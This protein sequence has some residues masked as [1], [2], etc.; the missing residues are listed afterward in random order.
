[1]KLSFVISTQSTKFK[2]ALFNKN[3]EENI[4]KISNLGYNGVELAVRDPNTLD[5]GKLKDLIDFH[6]LEVPAIGTGQAYGE[7]GLSFCDPKKKIRKK[8]VQRIKDQIELANELNAKVIIGL[9]RGN[10]KNKVTKEKA[11]NYIKESLEECCEYASNYNVELSLE[12]INRYEADLINT[13][14]EGL[15]IIKGL[16]NIGLLLDTFHMNIEEPLINESIVKA[17]KY[18]N[19]V[20]LADSNRW[21][22]GSGHLNLRTLIDV[23]RLNGYDGYFSAEILPKPEDYME[24]TIKHLK[25]LYGKII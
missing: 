21:A 7:E 18:I 17:S 6:N 12:P 23:F 22:P 15:E 25:R 24:K 5:V 16:D 20:H 8:A 3:L 14:E 9:I 13:V 10:L 11:L 19:H 1:M 4:K 2:A